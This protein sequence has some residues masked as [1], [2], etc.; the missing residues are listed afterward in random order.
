MKEPLLPFVSLELQC[1]GLCAGEA[2]YV[3]PMKIEYVLRFRGY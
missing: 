3:T 1:A 2:Q